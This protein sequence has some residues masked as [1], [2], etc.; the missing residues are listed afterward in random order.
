MTLKTYIK[1][2]VEALDD[3]ISAL[4]QII[5]KEG[6]FKVDPE[7]FAWSVMETSTHNATTVK[8]YL[9]GAERVDFNE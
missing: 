1:I 8:N 2:P 5:N 3:L 9:I 6:P 4:D 7:A